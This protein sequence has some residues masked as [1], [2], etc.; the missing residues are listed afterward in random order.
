MTLMSCQS[1][2]RFKILSHARVLIF[3]IGIVL[4]CYQ[5]GAGG[6]LKVE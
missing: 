6:E 2:E 4:I 3:E 1:L 5:H